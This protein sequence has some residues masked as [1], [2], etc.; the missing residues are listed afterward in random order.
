MREYKFRGKGLGT[1]QWKHG[2]L[3]V[4]DDED[5]VEC[6]IVSPDEGKVETVDCN[7]VGQYTGLYDKD[8]KEVYEGDILKLLTE[9]DIFVKIV[10]DKKVAG[11]LYKNGN[12][13]IMVVYDHEISDNFIIVGNIY[14]NPE[15]LEDHIPDAGKKEV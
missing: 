2:S 9:D 12:D 1:K 8:G 11:Y 14:D 3:V 5:D 15:L 10:W 4:L 13:G 6:Q 7:S